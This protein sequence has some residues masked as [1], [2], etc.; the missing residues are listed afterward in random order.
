M[1]V[2]TVEIPG[3]SAQFVQAGLHLP[4]GRP[5]PHTLEGLIEPSNSLA[6]PKHVLVACSLNQV[7]KDLHTDIQV[8]NVS[9]GPITLAKGTQSGT[10]IPLCNVFVVNSSMNGENPVADPS[11]PP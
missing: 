1:L 9:P 8:V 5:L 11:A 7:N 4:K 6:I 2:D 10:F 3:R